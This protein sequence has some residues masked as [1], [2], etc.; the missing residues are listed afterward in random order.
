MSGLVFQTDV[1]VAYNKYRI[2]NMYPFI[3][4]VAYSSLKYKTLHLTEFPI[5]VTL[6]DQ[7]NKY[8]TYGEDG[9][10]NEI[11][12]NYIKLPLNNIQVTL[13]QL[14]FLESSPLDFSII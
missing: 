7:K 8:W 2:K 13:L 14:N 3:F 9:L 12:D 10:L 11:F 1:L 5:K 4:F 6:P